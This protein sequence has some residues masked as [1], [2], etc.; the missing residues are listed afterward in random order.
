[1]LR[2]VEGF[3]IVVVQQPSKLR[4]WVRFPQPLVGF[5]FTELAKKVDYWSSRWLVYEKATIASVKFYFKVRI[6]EVR[7]GLDYFATEWGD[8]TR[9]SG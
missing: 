7:K 1:M 6:A 8:L 4:A 9:P 2:F 3:C 5:F